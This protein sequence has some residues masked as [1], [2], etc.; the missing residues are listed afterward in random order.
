MNTRQNKV[1][2]NLAEILQDS[3]FLKFAL[4][5]YKTYMMAV[6]E[7]RA[8]PD[9]RDGM[10]PISRRILWSAYDLGIKST[11]KPVK[12]ARIVGDVLGRFHPHGDTGT[13]K[14]M[15]GMTNR[16][17]P[18]PF[19][20]GDGNWGSMT[21]P[22]YAA[23]RYT[24][25][26]MGINAETLL[27]DRFYTPVL[28]FVPN[29]DGAG[30]EP[31]ILPAILPVLLLTGKVG[32]APGATTMIPSATFKSLIAFLKATYAMGKL[33]LMTALKTLRFTSTSGGVE[34]LPKTPE[35]REARKAF[36]TTIN[37]KIRL[38]STHT[39]DDKTATLTFTAF[40]DHWDISK[41]IDKVL[42]IE[43]VMSATDDTTKHDK[44]A[45]LVIKYRRGI[46][47]AQAQTL[48]NKIVAALTT[49]Q[50]VVLNFTER[51]VDEK[52][53]K[54][55]A[56]MKPMSLMKF[57]SEWIKYRVDLERRACAYWIGQASKHIRRLE[58]LM[59]ACDNLEFLFQLLKSKLDRP[60]MN[61][62]IAKQFKITVE[63]ANIIT[64]MKYYQLSRLERDA[65][66]AQ[67][68]KVIKDRAGLA[69]R[70]DNPMPYMAQQLDSF[71]ASCVV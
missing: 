24:E 37:G 12:S 57:F 30:K 20:K 60:A 49:T 35:E 3:E 33:D 50:H 9:Y 63:E 62:R 2:E 46:R 1:P 11:S 36:F 23:M 10:I 70:R 8:I 64:D 39:Y 15:V 71:A 56:R 38:G 69:K 42:K 27:F 26:R 52:T 19:I 55:E 51:Y 13:Y 67:K 44:Y 32:I 7:D 18:F 21:E 28:E 31:L 6:I 58:L 59:M 48:T 16:N 41:V 43:G 5:N 34:I 54:G 17:S 14:A 25:A 40:A 53:G 29:F 68:Q 66:E 65:L 61:A 47:G 4:G 22:A 45:R